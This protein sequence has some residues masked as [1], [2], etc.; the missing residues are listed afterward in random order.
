MAPNPITPLRAALTLREDTTSPDRLSA[1]IA[2]DWAQGRATYGGLVAALAVR[3][4][5]R[6][7]QG[8]PLRSFSMSFCAPVAPGDVSIDVELL[9]SGRSLLH[10]QARLSQAGQV[11][12]VLVGAYGGGRPSPVRAEPARPPIIPPPLELPRLPF[13]QG[14]TP[15]F[16]QHFEYRWASSNIP[17]TRAAEGQIGGWVRPLGVERIDEAV[18]AAIADSFPAPILPLM[19]APAPTST[20]TWMLSSTG[21]PLDSPADA[22]WQLDAT[23]LSAGEGYAHVDARLWDANGNLRMFS[24]Q[25]VAEFSAP[26]SPSAVGAP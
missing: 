18:C 9:R 14:K 23:T 10:S 7:N 19:P 4:L 8:R 6:V 17:F 12:A 24:R 13:L 25:L 1:T 22:F 2:P 15:T 26:V 11:C 3:A 16:T 5:T 21:E 20:V